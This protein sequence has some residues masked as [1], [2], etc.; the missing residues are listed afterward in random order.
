[1]MILQRCDFAILFR[2]WMD[3]I[4]VESRPLCYYVKTYGKKSLTSA[5]SNYSDMLSRHITN[6]VD[7]EY[8]SGLTVDIAGSYLPK[9]RELMAVGSPTLF[10]YLQLIPNYTNFSAVPMK[11]YAMPKLTVL[12]HQ[13]QHAK[14]CSFWLKASCM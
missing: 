11:D 14:S 7:P 6:I 1:Q 4:R 10:E 12:R 5:T 3:S 2:T 9:N 13:N 8:M